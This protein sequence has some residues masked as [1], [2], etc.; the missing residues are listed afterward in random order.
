M[1]I[2]N[3]RRIKVTNAISFTNDIIVIRGLIKGASL[4][5]YLFDENRILL[6]QF[7]L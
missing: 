3:N 6:A 7:F 1:P 5:S 4:T 2:D